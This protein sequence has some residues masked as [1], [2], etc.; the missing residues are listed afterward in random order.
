MQAKSASVVFFIAL[1]E[2]LIAAC[3]QKPATFNFDDFTEHKP[4]K[5]NT[6]Q[7]TPFGPA[8]ADIVARPENFLLCKGAPIA[9]CYYSGPEGTMTPCVSDE[10]H[11][12]RANCTCYEIP[13]GSPYLV[14]INAILNL[15]V[16]LD[17]V[18]T[19][20]HGGEDCLPRGKKQAPVCDSINNNTLIPGADLISTFSLFLE[21]SMPTN[22]QTTCAT[23]APYAGCMTGPCKR[24]G[25]FDE[26][27]G[28]PLV[29][30]AC[31]TYDGPYQ[32]SQDLSQTGN[33][34]ILGDPFLWSAAYAPQPGG[35]ISPPTA[36]P[37]YP[38]V[39]GDNGCPLL[40]PNPPYIPP[41][42]ADIDCN[43]VCSEYQNTNQAGVEIGFTCDATLCTATKS[44]LNLVA[45]ACAGLQ[46]S[47]VAEILKLETE[48]GYSCAASQ[49]CGCAPKTETNDE[50][51]N[52]NQSQRAT[53]ISPQCDLNGTLCGA[54]R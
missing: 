19:C 6:L 26:T 23:P 50:I 29:E 42:P 8:W 16:Y 48:V 11:K 30:C 54:P 3:G 4:F 25:G 33:K 51:F 49:I 40:S 35:K 17:T 22:Q 38:D 10:Q 31:P 18:A 1:V 15:N 2:C 44:D 21:P 47:P 7:T 24:T 45:E 41:P 46:N 20:G 9:L 39:P 27:T 32:V 12:G 53:G 13:G 34:C 14:D 5:L 43:K 52:L 36:P 37:C 28:L